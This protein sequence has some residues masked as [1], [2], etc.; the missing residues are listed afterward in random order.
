MEPDSGEPSPAAR[1]QPQALIRL[2]GVTKRFG[3]HTVFEDLSLD[4]R[5]GDT[6]VVLG[7]SGVGK[8]VMLKL[9]LGLLLPDAGHIFVD[10]AEITGLDERAMI[11]IRQRFGMVF[12][13]SALF[14]FL[15]VYENVAFA[16]REHKDW[17]EAKVRQTVRAKLA[18]VDLEGTEAL[19][20][21]ELSGGMRKRVGLARAIAIDPEVILYDEPTTGLDPVTADTINSLIVRCQRELRT[22]SIVVTHDMASAYKVGDRL[23]MLHAG[24]II[25]DGPPEAIRRHPDLRV[26]RFV[27][28]NAELTEPPTDGG[29]P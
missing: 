23:V 20:P 5:R 12:Q 11:P 4:I 14:D 15:T 18:T 26:Q 9:I 27:H 1:D 7:A 6:T 2:E 16:M 25:A 19:L 3:G 10:H 17:P 22:T 28:G 29:D 24:R 21:E 13:G 8:S